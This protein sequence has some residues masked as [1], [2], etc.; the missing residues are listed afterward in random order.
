MIN[1]GDVGSVPTDW[2]VSSFF[3]PFPDLPL[4]RPEPDERIRP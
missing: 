1:R 3:P 4:M 2:D